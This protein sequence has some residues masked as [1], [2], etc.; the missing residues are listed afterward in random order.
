[1]HNGG[2][3]ADSWQETLQRPAA[4]AEMHSKR[5]V[6]ACAMVGLSGRHQSNGPPAQRCAASTAT[7]RTTRRSCAWR[8]SPVSARHNYHVK[9]QTDARATTAVTHMLH[10]GQCSA[11]RIL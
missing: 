4:H 9:H 11:V 6:W 10:G 7:V 3:I 1:M 5:T 8:R 2:H